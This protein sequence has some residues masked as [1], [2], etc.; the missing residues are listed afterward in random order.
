MRD[1]GIPMD[2][3]TLDHPRQ[4][5]TDSRYYNQDRLLGVCASVCKALILEYLVQR[6]E[7]YICGI[8]QESTISPTFPPGGIGDGITPW[9]SGKRRTKQQ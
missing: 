5:I 3:K 8:M 1:K 2:C 7:K 4:Y 9:G 6:C